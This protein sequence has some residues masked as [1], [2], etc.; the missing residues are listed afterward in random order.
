MTS[1]RLPW[2]DRMNLG[3]LVAVAVLVMLTTL[4]FASVSRLVESSQETSHSYKVLAGAEQVLAELRA[5]ESRERGYVVSGDAEFLAQFDQAAARIQPDLDRLRALAGDDAQVRRRVAALEP[6][7]EQRVAGLRQVVA[8]RRSGGEQATID[9]IHSSRGFELSGRIEAFVADLQADVLKLAEERES[10][11]LRGA[12][13]TLAAFGVGLAVAMLLL[14][15]TVRGWRRDLV[16]RVDA[17]RMAHET[18]RLTMIIAAQSAIAAEF[19]RERVARLVI[20]QARQVTGFSGAMVDLVA[21][22]DDPWPQGFGALP[23]DS[24]GAEPA[25][26]TLDDDD[27]VVPAVLTPGAHLPLDLFRSLGARSLAVAPLV[28]LGR[29]L[30][31]LRVFSARPVAWTVESLG[32]LQLLAGFA[33]AAFSHAAELEAKEAALN[34]L[35][36]SKDAADG[37]SRAKSEFLASMS[38]ELRT[39]LN[40]IIGFSEILRDQRFGPLNLRQVRYI[41]NVLTSGR[42]LLQLVNDVL[43]LSKVE[44]GRMELHPTPI[45]LRETLH[46]AVSIVQALAQSKHIEIDLSLPDLRPT[47]IADQ[48]KLKQM[49]YNLLSNAVKFTPAGGVV[50]VEAQAMK[51]PELAARAPHGVLM[52]TVADNGIGISER[53]QV[54]IFETFEQ[55]DSPLARAQPGTGLGLAL[56]R[57]LVELH[58]GRIWVDSDG[59]G[60]GSAF[61]FTLPLAAAAAAEEMLRELAAAPVLED[62]GGVWRRDRHPAAP[63]VTVLVVDDE[64]H[65]RELIRLCLRPAGYTVVEAVD[66]E[67]A[68]TMAQALQPQLITLDV[69]LPKRDGWQVLADLR[70]DAAT[71]DI[72]VVMVTITEDRVLAQHFGAQAFLVKP[73]DRE[74]LVGL[75]H[76]LTGRAIGS[77]A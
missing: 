24:S 25:A 48:G 40:S 33:A 31:E 65:A 29:R 58:G 70:A 54:R 63:P 73:L 56:T 18:E 55:V 39:P 43:D 5:A 4:Q 59:P 49:L 77:H 45:E 26:A 12:K 69:L 1:W 47:L 30:G 41:E 71:R 53:D 14:L 28:R 57:K 10:A 20:E 13:Q 8:L 34:E 74:L 11:L 7:I 61:R 72:P 35:R 76:E 37:A 17:A 9:Q 22:E 64:P 50:H 75:A 51:E 6:L 44:S 16:R 62:T 2:L 52:I 46:E 32:D 68:V 38:H 21:G 42:H 36:R 60:K 66:G 3:I 15:M 27:R 67:Q 23:A 19:R